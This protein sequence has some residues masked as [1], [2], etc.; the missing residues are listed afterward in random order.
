[1]ASVISSPT[2]VIVVQPPTMDGLIERLGR[3]PLSRVLSHPA[4][5]HATEADLIEAQRKYDRLY[6]LVDGVLV[7]KGIGFAESFRLPAAERKRRPPWFH[8]RSG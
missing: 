2:S 7:E 6:E 1:M 4:P 3:I 8:S 5:D